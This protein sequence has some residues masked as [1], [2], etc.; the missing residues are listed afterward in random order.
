M[1]KYAKIAVSCLLVV[2]CAGC[3]NAQ[4]FSVESMAPLEAMADN[5]AKA[6]RGFVRDNKIAASEL[7]AKELATRA[8]AH[9]PSLLAPYRERGFIVKGEKHGIVLICTGDEM[10]ALIQDAACTTHVDD[11]SW[12]RENAPCEFTLD[13]AAICK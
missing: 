1:K 11:R 8:T 9:D 12:Q 2:F 6:I 4:E 7:D 10:R 5:L 13:I 3:A